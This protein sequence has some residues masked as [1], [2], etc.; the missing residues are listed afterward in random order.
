MARIIYGKR[1][2]TPL[3]GYVKMARFSL[4]EVISM[5]FITCLCILGYCLALTRLSK[6]RIE[7]T[8]FFIISSIITLLYIFAYTH[9][10]QFGTNAL[11]LIGGLL[12]ILSPLFLFSERAIFFE[13]YATPGLIITLCFSALFLSLANQSHLSAWD[14][15]THW[16]PHS[17]LVFYHNGFLTASD[18]TI[19]KSYPLGGALFQYFFFRLSGYSEGVAYVAQTLLLMAPLSIFFAHYHWQ[20]WKRAFIVYSFVLLVLLALKVKIGVTNSLYMDTA[21]GIYVGMAIVS[22][23]SSSKTITN[24][25]Y[26]IPIITAMT[27][28]KQKLMPFVLLISAVIFIVQLSNRGTRASKRAEYGTMSGSARLL[29]RAFLSLLT[30]PLSAIL[31]TDSWH[32]YLKQINQSVEWKM[33]FSFTKLHDAFLAPAGSIPHTIIANYTHALTPAFICVFAIMMLNA[34][35]FYFSK[36]NKTTIAI[37]RAILLL[38]FIA[39]AFALL[40]MYLFSF[41]AYEGI[42]HAS[43]NRYLNIYFVAWSLVTLYFLFDAFLRFNIKS[44]I[45]NGFIITIMIGLLS[46]ITLHFTHQKHSLSPLR[47]PINHIANVVK[48]VVPRNA[49]V[50]T[51]WQDGTGLERGIL[52][53]ELTPRIANM[54]CTSFGKKYNANDVWTCD[55]KPSKLAQ[56]LNQFNFVLLAYTDKNFW[57][58]YQSILPN[59]NNLKPFA[60]Y[61]ICKGDGFD[62]FGKSGCHMA[63]EHAYLFKVGSHGKLISVS[64]AEHAADNISSE[65][66][67]SASDHATF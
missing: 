14:E 62:S 23:L 33:D 61:T 57:D 48:N 4:M 35:A 30:L 67:G 59:K 5:P 40:L 42:I 54:G 31:I 13:K 36:G 32:H 20:S 52:L 29:T 6:W 21:V 39:Y 46:W 24:I 50:F 64:S 28:F 18:V 16:G 51:I 58:H 19:H 17:K 34:V 12:F 7:F 45:E 60:T 37:V 55:I 63:T 56:Q 27:L 10:L 25:L 26:L 66:S 15:F 49:S 43:M 9:T 47:E 41:S 65:G 11:L 3:I 38:G 2:W 8:P 53:Y 1:T 44:S 22:F